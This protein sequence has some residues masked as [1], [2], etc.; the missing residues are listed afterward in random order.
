MDNL[1]CEAAAGG[2]RVIASG[3]V[4]ADEDV[5]LA[6][7]SALQRITARSDPDTVALIIASIRNCSASSRFRAEALIVLAQ[8]AA[9]GDS[10][11]VMV[12]LECLGEDRCWDGFSVRTNA[13]QLLK[14]LALHG[15]G[16]VINTLLANVERA[17]DLEVRQLSIEVL[18]SVVEPGSTRALSL[19][20]ALSDG[21]DVDLKLAAERALKQVTEKSICLHPPL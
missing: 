20:H 18:S 7:L 15:D 12:A 3:L 13:A 21:D 1:A 17:D 9:R 16:H 2:I 14:Q 8:M 11:A 4:D 10:N 5:A 19:L 6:A